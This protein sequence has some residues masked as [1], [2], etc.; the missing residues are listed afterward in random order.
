MA[1]ANDGY[2]VLEEGCDCYICKLIRG[3]QPPKTEVLAEHPPKEK[4]QPGESTEARNERIWRAI[5]D[6]AGG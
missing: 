6:A 3:Y 5:K 1:T 4:P 2:W